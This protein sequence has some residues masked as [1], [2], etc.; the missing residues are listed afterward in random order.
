MSITIVMKCLFVE[1]FRA[2]N[3]SSTMVLTRHAGFVRDCRPHQLGRRLSVKFVVR[4]FCGSRSNVNK[5]GELE[6]V[7]NDLVI[8]VCTEVY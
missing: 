2:A 5:R 6:E 3:L 7:S 1:F 4:N 8:L